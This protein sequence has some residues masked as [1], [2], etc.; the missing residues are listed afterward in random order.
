MR[1]Y[2]RRPGRLVRR[3]QPLRRLRRARRRLARRAIHASAF[4]LGRRAAGC[5]CRRSCAARRSRPAPSSTSATAARAAA[6]T[7]PTTARA[8]T[9]RR[10]AS[11]ATRARCSPASEA[12]LLAIALLLTAAAALRAHR[13]RRGRRD[14]GQAEVHRRARQRVRHRQRRRRQGRRRA[15]G[16]DH[17]PAPGPAHKPRWST[18]RSPRT[19]FGSLRADTFCE[20]R[21]QSL[22][23][24]YFIDCDPGTEQDQAEARRHDPGRAHRVDDPRRPGQRHHAPPVA[25]AAADHPQRARRRRRRPLDRPQRDD[26]PRRCRRCARPTS[27]LV[28]LG[29]QNQT[30]KQPDDRRGRRDRRPRRQPQERRAL[31][32]ET[33]KAAGASA[34]RRQDIAAGL[35]RLP[36]FLRELQADDGR[37]R[38]D[39]RR[40]RPPRCADL[41]ASAGQ[42]TRLLTDLPD[43]A[44]ASR[45]RTFNSLAD[46][47]EPGG[48]AVKAAQP[49]VAELNKGTAEAPR[50]RQQPGLS[51]SRDLDDRNRAVEK[52]PRSPGGKGY[53]GFEAV[54][55]YMFDQAMAINIF[56]ANGYILKVNL[57][58][59]GVQRLPERRVARRRSCRRTRASSATASPVSAR[60]SPASRTRRP[61]VHGRRERAPDAP[62]PPAQVQEEAQAT[63]TTSAGAT[64]ERARSPPSDGGNDPKQNAAG[65]GPSCRRCPARRRCPAPTCRRLPLPQRPG[66]RRSSR[67]PTAPRS[68]TRSPR[69]PR[70]PPRPMRGRP[71]HLCQPRPRRRGHRA[72]DA[73]SPCSWPTT[74][75][76]GLPFVPTT[77][78]NVRCPT[79]RTSSRATRCA[80]A[81][82]AS[83]WST[84]M[85]PVRLAAARSAPSSRSS[86]TSRSATSRATRRLRIRA[87]LG[88]RPQVRRADRRASRAGSV[89]QRRH[90]RRSTVGDTGR[91]RPGLQDVRRARRARRPQQNLRGFGDAFAGRGA[92]RRAHDRGAPRAVRPPRAGDAQPGRPGHRARAA[93]SSELGDAAADRSRRSS[94]TN[95]QLFT[96]MADTFEAIGRDP[97]GAQARR[98]PRRRRRWTRRSPRSAS[99][100]RSSTDLTAFSTDLSG[101]TSE[102]RGAL[103]TINRAHRD[104]HAG[105][106]APV[107]RSTTRLR[108]HDRR[109]P[110]T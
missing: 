77:E 100:A 18:S 52:D 109:R 65:A 87:A 36:T 14:A 28:M 110:R 75:T 33:R 9:S 25:R 74:P 13:R 38:R 7:G 106:E 94:K 72:R 49:T 89:R 42:L 97:R 26:P 71:A 105:A 60:T 91:A 108:G 88:A 46:A 16:Q 21:P 83:A 44:D 61:D 76:T 86:S 47:A 8:R 45:A 63:A 102:L 70:L 30:L 15:R 98:S 107:P 99:S 40:R 41:N 104:R 80:P 27:V 92:G 58:V 6:S 51:S 4:T 68:A 10:P 84:D 85:A 64:P 34:E 11:T 3:L 81:A 103:P 20:V 5:R 1:P 43:F 79:A 48:R 62:S 67:S 78:L 57:F 101:A 39:R 2:T 31:R 12:R 50:A 29:R 24:E 96:S 55:Q 73:S 19:G 59:V 69:P 23:G 35:Q 22:I 53:T 17:R 56:D 37:A 82:T 54:L 90:G 66:S 32:H 95:A 93:S